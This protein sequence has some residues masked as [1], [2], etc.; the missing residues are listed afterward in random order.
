M[1]TLERVGVGC[2]AFSPLAQGLLTDHYLDSIP[3]APRAE[4]GRSLSPDLLSD[5]AST[6]IRALNELAEPRGQS[7][8]QLALDWALRDPRVT[9][10]LIGA[11]SVGGAP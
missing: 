6:R 4:T 2:I 11:C 1:L 8:A 3:A 7:F 9:S 5:E 10:A